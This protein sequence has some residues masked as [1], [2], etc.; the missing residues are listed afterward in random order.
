MYDVFGKLSD[1][2]K[3]VY[4]NILV[5]RI[6]KGVEIES[7]TIDSGV[8]YGYVIFPWFFSVSMDFV[9]EEV[10]R[11]LGVMGMRFSEEGKQ[12]EVSYCFFYRLR[13]IM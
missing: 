5:W 6:V 13:G 12:V 8:K 4:V 9:T 2:I 10:K 1:Y 7:F 11:E 3:I